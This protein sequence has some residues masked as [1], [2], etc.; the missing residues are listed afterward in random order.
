MQIIFGAAQLVAL[1]DSLLEPDEK[2]GRV[3]LST[4]SDDRV[5]RERLLRIA[6]D[7][8]GQME[9]D[10]SVEDEPDGYTVWIYGPR[11]RID[12]IAKA[13]GRGV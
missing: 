8:A 13:V 5:V 6:G 4:R 10:T 9:C 11:V 7:M 3:A 12:T 2:L 1:V